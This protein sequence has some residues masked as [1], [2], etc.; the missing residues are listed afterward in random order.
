MSNFN[1]LQKFANFWRARSRLYQNEILQVNTKYAFDSIFQ[2]LQDLHTFAPLRSQNFRKKSVWKISNFCKNT[3]TFLHILENLQNCAVF[4]KLQLDH[5]VDFEK[6]CKTRIY[7]PPLGGKKTQAF[8]LAPPKNLLS[9][10]LVSHFQ[11]ICGVT[12]WDDGMVWWCE[13]VMMWWCDHE[14]IG[15]WRPF[16]DNFSWISEEKH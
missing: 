3:A 14:I 5:L 1:F 8:W 12:R 13:V 9:V 6:C 11:S 10:M 4:Q 7:T 2:A 15:W 16:L